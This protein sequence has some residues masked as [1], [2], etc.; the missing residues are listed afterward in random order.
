MNKSLKQ[1]MRRRNAQ[2]KNGKR[3]GDF[4][5]FRAARNRFVDLLRKSKKNYFAQLNPRDTKKFWK[6]IK[7]LN[8]TSQAVPTLSHNG[9]STSEDMGKAN[10][11]NAF[12][13]TCFNTSDPPLSEHDQN[14]YATNECPAEL[15]CTVEQV[16]CLLGSLDTTKATG[17]DGVSA[18]MLKH[19]AL[20]IAP[21]VTKLFN[22]SISSG[23]VPTDWKRSTVVPIPKS[24]DRSSP[25]NYRPISL[26]SILSKT[27]ERHIHSLIAT[28]LADNQLLSDRQWGFLP[29]KGTVTALLATTHNWFQSLE[30]NKD[31]CAVFFD[32][33]KAFD[34]VAHR[35]LLEKMSQLSINET[36]IQWVS[37]YLTSR[38][39][40]VVLNGATSDSANVLSGVPQGS[41]LG[42]LLFIIYV[43]D[44]AAMQLSQ[45]SQ[46]ILYADDLLLFRPISTSADYVA[47]QKDISELE[48][49]TV[50]NSLQFNTAKCNYMVITR[51]RCPTLPLNPLIL[52]GV[53]LKQVDMFKYLGL[54]ITSDLSWSRHI[55]SICSRAKRILGMLY[56]QYYHNVDCNTMRCLYLSLVRPHLEYGCS[57]WDPHTQKDIQALERV[58]K[59]ACKMATQNW[60]AGCDELNDLVNLPSLQHRRLQLK[61]C[62]LYKIIHGLSY[63]PDDIFI[64]RQN[65][66]N[67]SSNNKSLLQPFAHTN[68]FLFSFVPHTIRTWNSLSTSQVNAVSLSSF[69]F[70]L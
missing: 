69:K 65:F 34:S 10:M 26:L 45:D 47:L 53:T 68:A 37:S 17:P 2:Y 39:Q 70:T 1:A 66:S 25:T 41:V 67:R 52:N 50:N 54:L 61:L 13:S 31:V 20:F 22:L 46:I 6:T 23:Q 57:V 42:P 55:D 14:P 63:F 64:P 51:R 5:K 11:L 24:S 58:Q 18:T 30:N 3:T 38:R 9:V 56:R 32:Y 28:H 33:R 7:S 40:S 15:L 35:P 12:F 59:F 48:P 21:S 19:T 62:Q 49:W 43:N 44:L 27:L 8:K 36:I 60:N 29:G 16:Q 4:S